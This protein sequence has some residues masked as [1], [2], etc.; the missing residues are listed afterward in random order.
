MKYVSPETLKAEI[1]KN[2]KSFLAQKTE[3]DPSHLR[4]RDIMRSLED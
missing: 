3:S 4:I 2:F 1:M